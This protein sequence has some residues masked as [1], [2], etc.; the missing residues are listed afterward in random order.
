MCV[1]AFVFVRATYL[2]PFGNDQQRTLAWTHIFRLLKLIDF[3][4]PA[5]GVC[6]RSLLRHDTASGLCHTKIPLLFIS[7]AS[8]IQNAIQKKN[9]N[10]PDGYARYAGSN[11]RGLGALAN[12]F[13]DLFRSIFAYFAKSY[14][15]PFHAFCVWFMRLIGMDMLTYYLLSAFWPKSV[16]FIVSV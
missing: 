3:Y 8:K 11:R 1:C 15:F 5:S 10:S 2:L 12:L 7:F 16:C 13:V 6:F 9:K 14:R 4:L